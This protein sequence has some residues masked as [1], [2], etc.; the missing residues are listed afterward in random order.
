MAPHTPRLPWERRP[1]ETDKSFDAFKVYRNLGTARSFP[2]AATA[3]G[4]PASYRNQLARWSSRFDWV[5]RAE[6]WDRVQ[7][8]EVIAAA[9]DTVDLV[10]QLVEHAS[11]E[12]S[13]P[14]QKASHR[15][16][17]VLDHLTVEESRRRCAQLLVSAAPQIVEGVID[18]A[19]METGDDPKLEK[20]KLEASRYALGLLGLQP[21]KDVNV[22]LH[23]AVSGDDEPA[24]GRGAIDVESL[25]DEE[26]EALVSV[27]GRLKV[28]G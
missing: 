14:L 27:G 12:M 9:A 16:R 21:P 10:D 4:R 20:V 22:R 17:R 26:L 25:S 15:A 13:A 2:E 8:S 24:Q 6:A 19:T 11:P 1:D 3:L 23:E 28:A 5:S 7:S 18:Q